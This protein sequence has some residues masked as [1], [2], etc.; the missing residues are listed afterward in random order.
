MLKKY[1]NEMNI[2]F[3]TDE[4]AINYLIKENQR[5]RKISYEHL[6]LLNSLNNSLAGRY[7]LKKNGYSFENFKGDSYSGN[8][9]SIRKK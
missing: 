9:I 2:E 7:L 8:A 3:D 4:E 6:D 5:L 1:L